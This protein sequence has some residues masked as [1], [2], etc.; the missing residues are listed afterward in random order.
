MA[1]GAGDFKRSAA[2]NR[3]LSCDTS[4]L[5]CYS[6]ALG[7]LLIIRGFA[8]DKPVVVANA[9]AAVILVHDE[10]GRFVGVHRLTDAKQVAALES[11]FPPTKI[12]RRAELQAGGD[13]G[14][15]STS[16]RATVAPPG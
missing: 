1:V 11:F 6:S 10:R 5:V 16:T 4:F 8:A 3:R 7:G 15:R 2:E 9:T 14:I 12:G 13:S